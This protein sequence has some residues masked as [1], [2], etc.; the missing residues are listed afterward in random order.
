MDQPLFAKA[1]ILQWA[2]PET[3]GETQF[4]FVFGSLHIEQKF[5]RV[6]G[7]WLEHNGW[8]GVLVQT[9]I[10]TESKVDACIKVSHIKKT[11][12]LLQVTAAS[13]G[14]LLEE[15]FEEN[16]EQVAFEDWCSEEAK[17]HPL[18]K[19]WLISLQ[20]LKLLFTFVR[21]IRQRNFGLYL[22][23]LK[24]MLPWFFVMDHPNYSR[25]LSVHV[26]DLV[27]LET[28]APAIYRRFLTGGFAIC[29]THRPFSAIGIDQA[30]EQNN[31][32]VKG[33]GGAIGLTED[34][35]AL[36]RWNI[37]G[38]LLS[39]LINE[40]EVD[41][42]KNS[43]PVNPKH[44]EQYRS[45]QTKFL[46]KV[47]SVRDSFNEFGNPFSD[48]SSELFVLDSK[49]VVQADIVKTI[50]RA[51]STG[52]ECYNKFRE[53]RFVRR[54]EPLIAAI[55]RTNLPLFASKK[56]RR[57]Y[58]DEHVRILK[59]DVELF[60]RLFIVSQ[61]RQLDLDTFFKYENQPFPPAL[62]A[63]G[64]LYLGQK[65]DLLGLLETVQ[66]NAD[67]TV[68]NRVTCDGLI[69]D[70]AALVNI[71]HPGKEPKTFDQ[72]YSNTFA[73]H[74]TKQVT[75]VNATR[76]DVVWDTYVKDSLKEQT[77]QKRGTGVKMVVRLSGALP[78]S[79]KD[80]LRN[81][82]NKQQLFDLLASLTVERMGSTMAV[83]SN[84]HNNVQQ[85]TSASTLPPTVKHEEADTRIF[86][87]LTDM[88]TNGITKIGIQTVDTDVLVLALANFNKLY[89][90]G[91]RELWLLFGTG[92]NY[93]N[94]PVHRIAGEI[95][96]EMCSALPGFHAYSGCDT[97]S[98]FVGRG[99]KTAWQ[100]WNAF[101]A[102][103]SA[104][105]SISTVLRSLPDDVFR[106]L[107]RFTCLMYS[108][109]TE[110]TEVNMLRKEQFT[111]GNK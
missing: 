13:L 12:Y 73:P 11:A 29:K 68:S 52:L 26:K 97:V 63:D 17:Q 69:I 4:V 35:D 23:S 64:D 15:A 103:T 96:T 39:E 28:T 46:K 98:A 86:V 91:L 42:N 32:V 87:H 43:A 72:Y 90:I 108:S 89:A 21:S 7:Q 75:T 84:V 48:D 62:S 65:A 24:K 93:R 59:L 99:K 56:K 22:T 102:V 85:S 81:S 9:G 88:V 38:P 8:K 50:N 60:S 111:I 5:M 41:L 53:E 101:P 77:R 36:R 30:H 104:F 6:I 109:S 71:L 95:G 55:T 100:T 92:K 47:Q 74:L 33:D 25:W 2:W 10:Y 19:Y 27:E 110:Q 67:N 80:F 70:G 16:G 1:K 76:L 61:N 49:V 105:T 31:A 37:V 20:L 34:N 45:F 82:D 78:R 14:I 106:N 3:Y 83:V 58:D 94:I 107:E 66:D 18:F 40:F 57:T 79:W 44:H 54:S 51:E